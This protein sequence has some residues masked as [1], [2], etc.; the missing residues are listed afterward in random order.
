LV[1]SDRDRS[2]PGRTWGGAM[3]QEAMIGRLLFRPPDV[4]GFSLV[5]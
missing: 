2:R 1:V 3:R 4:R 5:G